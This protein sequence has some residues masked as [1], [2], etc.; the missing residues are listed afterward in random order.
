MTF[1]PASPK[2]S[3]SAVL[4]E[5]PS[6]TEGTLDREVDLGSLSQELLDGLFDGVYFVD[7][8]RKIC[9][10]NEGAREL[11]GF[12]RA[13][14]LDRHCFD[15]LLAHV[16][17]KGT[18]LCV[19][20]C[21]LSATLS[22]GQRREA[23]VYLRHKEG[24][25]VPVCVRVA[26]IRNRDG[27]IIGA[28]E[29]FSDISAKKSLERRAGELEQMVHLDPLTGIC[30][31]RYM[32][33]KL[34]QAIDELEQFGKNFG[35]LM[36]DLDHFKRINDKFGHAAGDVV[37]K[38]AAETIAHNLRVTDTLGRWGGEEFLA[39]VADV[40]ARELEMVAEKC[41]VLVEQSSVVFGEKRVGMAASIGAVMIEPGDTV[42][43]AVNR[44]DELLYRSKAMGRNRV[45]M[46]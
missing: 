7:R 37:L 26:P 2:R 15:D 24:H 17:E 28:V 14:M 22:D 41:R 40:N 25:R 31:R 20:E 35:L 36:I 19:D 39:L 32:M 8:K 38:M 45:T 11:T 44:A 29:V 21:P 42:D 5:A 10:W 12:S 1:D 23:E 3:Q 4:S 30:N 46:V 13:D 33:L 6:S 27:A 43:S 18:C 16:D 9:Y 34:G